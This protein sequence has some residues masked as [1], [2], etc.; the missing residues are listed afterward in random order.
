MLKFVK[1]RNNCNLFCSYKLIQ[2]VFIKIF[3]TEYKKRE[4]S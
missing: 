3:L 2:V 1:D 4:I